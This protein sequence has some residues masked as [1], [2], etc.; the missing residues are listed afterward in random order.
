MRCPS[1]SCFVGNNEGPRA[2]S[3]TESAV[4]ER[5]N[6]AI[7]LREHPHVPTEECINTRRKEFGSIPNFINVR[8]CQ[9]T[10][11]ALQPLNRTSQ[12]ASKRGS[13]L[14][15]GSALEHDH[16]RKPLDSEPGS[17]LAPVMAR[18]CLIVSAPHSLLTTQHSI[19]QCRLSATA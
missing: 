12:E 16:A 14:K 7:N 8:H 4:G 9:P 15:P 17:P 19:R 18:C 5:A 10:A 11:P 2:V 6:C 1:L 3:N 13:S